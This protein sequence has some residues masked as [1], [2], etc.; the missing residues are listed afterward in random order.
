MTVQPYPLF[1]SW[2]YYNDHNDQI[3]ARSVRV[4]G[5]EQ[6][7]DATNDD[8]FDYL[9]P[10]LLE[11]SIPIAYASEEDHDCTICFAEDPETAEANA[12]EAGMPMLP[13]WR[14]AHRERVAALRPRAA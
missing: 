7:H 8:S 6:R 3:A 4:I 10:V 5:W 13:D 11:D 12:R 2:A 9:A 14:E 1:A